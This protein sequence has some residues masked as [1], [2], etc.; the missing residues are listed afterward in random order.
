IGVP[1]LETMAG[2]PFGLGVGRNQAFFGE[3]GGQS[4]FKPPAQEDVDLNGVVA[5]KDAN[6]ANNQIRGST[7]Q[8]YAEKTKDRMQRS[9]DLADLPLPSLRGETPVIKI[10]PKSVDKGVDFYKFALVARMDL[11]GTNMDEIRGAARQIWDFSVKIS[12]LGRGY[13]IF[14]LETQQDLDKLWFGGPWFIKKQLLRFSKWTPNFSVDKQKNTMAAVWVKFPGLSME[15]WEVDILMAMG[16]TIGSPMHVDRNTIE[17]DMGYYASVLVDV[18]LSEPIPNKILVEVED[19]NIEFWQDVQLGKL[20]SFC[21]NCKTIG[22]CVSQCRFLKKDPQERTEKNKEPAVREAPNDQD[23]TAGMSKGQK[24]R[25]KKK[26]KDVVHETTSQPKEPMTQTMEAGNDNEGGHPVLVPSQPVTDNPQ[27]VTD[28]PQQPID[29]E[30]DTKESDVE[31][32]PQA[33]EN[34]QLEL[35]VQLDISSE[36]VPETQEEELVESDVELISSAE[37]LV[38]HEAAYIQ[39][40]VLEESQAHDGWQI[41]TNRKKKK[42]ESLSSATS[43]VASRLRTR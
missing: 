7:K 4:V 34:N 30:S 24:K 9:V 21:N 41:K 36:V 12:P 17:R 2:L 35:F 32:S 26:A 10:S 25:Y 33:S 28:N 11:K 5:V 19:R 40:K 27:P 23:P 18:D 37:N 14:K 20:P 43:P 16:R 38:E 22:H 39:S 3:G 31:G 42:N 15:Y 6:P 13:L 29:V 8:S 1:W